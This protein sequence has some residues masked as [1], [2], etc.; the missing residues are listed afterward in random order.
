V[1]RIGACTGAE[2]VNW[3][4]ERDFYLTEN[5][6]EVFRAWRRIVV[7]AGVS[8][9][10]VHDARLAAV[11]RVNGIANILTFNIRHFQRLPDITAV[12]PQEVA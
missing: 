10:Q 11:M 9:V 12:H 7:E 6:Q 4:V 5:T 2:L 8:G 3:L 1:R